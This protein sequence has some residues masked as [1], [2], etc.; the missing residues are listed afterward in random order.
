MGTDTKTQRHKHTKTQTHRDTTTQRHKDPGVRSRVRVKGSEV[1]AK[2]V[3]IR[4]TG[5]EG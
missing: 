1:R 4:G 2:H 3:G 5:L